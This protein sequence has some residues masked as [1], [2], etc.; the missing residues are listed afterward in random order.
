MAFRAIS[1]RSSGGIRSFR[2]FPEAIPPLRP[3]A[4][5][6][7]FLRPMPFNIRKRL[8]IVKIFLL[9][10]LKR[11]SIF[12]CRERTP[13]RLERLGGSGTPQQ[14]EGPQDALTPLI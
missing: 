3:K 4:T 9:T 13:E 8:R 1:E 6:W 10:I 7:G 14:P 5:A 11:F 2:T 12:L